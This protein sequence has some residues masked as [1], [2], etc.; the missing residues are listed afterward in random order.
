MYTNYAQTH[1][2]QAQYFRDPRN[3]HDLQSYLTANTFLTDIN[4]EVPESKDA[5]RHY[6]KNLASLDALVLILFSEDKTVVPKESGWFGS[7]KPVNPSEPDAVSRCEPVTKGTR[8]YSCQLD[9][10]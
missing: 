6:K 1:I 7:Y 3:A 8:I 5:A 9:A 10:G 4:V 2:I